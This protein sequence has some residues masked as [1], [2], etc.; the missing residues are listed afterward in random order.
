MHSAHHRDIISVVQIGNRHTFTEIHII[1]I[2]HIPCK[3][4]VNNEIEY[5]CGQRTLFDPSYGECG[6]FGSLE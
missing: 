2:M 3:D 4:S 1:V 6:A 5:Y